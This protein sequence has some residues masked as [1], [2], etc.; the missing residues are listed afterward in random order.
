MN[1][2]PLDPEIRKAGFH[3]IRGD[4]REIQSKINDLDKRLSNLL[5]TLIVFRWFAV[6]ATGTIMSIGWTTCNG[7]VEN[8]KQISINTTKILSIDS[9]LTSIET[10]GSSTAKAT[11]ASVTDLQQRLNAFAARYE[12]F[13][14]EEIQADSRIPGILHQLESL[15]DFKKEVEQQGSPILRQTAK[16]VSE[17]RQEVKDQKSQLIGLANFLLRT[18]QSRHE[19]PNN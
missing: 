10:G 2:D 17:L 19:P 4:Y 12:L 1:D 6:A 13:V 9:R 3:Q 7:V 14:R 18:T 16:E 15:T 8:E 5:G 11:L